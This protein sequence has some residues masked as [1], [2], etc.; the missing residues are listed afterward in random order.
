M[1]ELNNCLPRR[2]VT[3]ELSRHAVASEK[4]V[5][6][7]EAQAKAGSGGRSVSTNS[8]SGAARRSPERTSSTDKG[9]QSGELSDILA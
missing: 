4:E 1:H 7:T 5:A 6:K 3:S 9:N 2:L 8:V